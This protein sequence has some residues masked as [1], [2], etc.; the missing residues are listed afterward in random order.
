MNSWTESEFEGRTVLV[1][2]S[3]HASVDTN[4]RDKNAPFLHCTRSVP[5]LTH[6][7]TR[8]TV[9]ISYKE[10]IESSRAGRRSIST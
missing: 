1:M 3:I 6:H 2:R 10:L 5:A 7:C 8:S 4:N 9:L